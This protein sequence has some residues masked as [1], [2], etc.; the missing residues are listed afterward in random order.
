MYSTRQLILVL[1]SFLALSACDNS[2]DN[3]DQTLT[4]QIEEP[5]TPE[6]YYSQAPQKKVE[7][8]G[9]GIL[10]V[11]PSMVFP[12]IDI[13]SSI[14]ETTK[15]ISVLNG[16]ETEFAL[17]G[18]ETSGDDAFIIEQ[19]E[20]AA[21]I[22]PGDTCSI[23]VK[24][25]PPTVGEFKGALVFASEVGIK[26]TELT[27]MAFAPKAEDKPIAMPEPP[28]PDAYTIWRNKKIA[29]RA[30]ARP[31]FAERKTPP[32]APPVQQWVN[33]DKDY[34][35]QKTPTMVSTYPVDRTFKLTMERPINVISDH[36]VIS[37]LPGIAHF[38]VDEIVLGTDGKT[39]ILDKGDAFVTRFEPL[40]KL[41]DRRVN[42]CV[43]RIIRKKDGAAFYLGNEEGEKCFAHIV[44]AEGV[45]GLT[46]EVDNRNW[47]KYG[48]AFLTAT[49]S[50]AATYGSTQLSNAQ[51]INQAGTTLTDQLGE[52]TSQMIQQ[53]IDLAPIVTV[54]AGER[55]GVQLDTDLYLKR[56]EPIK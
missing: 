19:N 1:G 47:E 55:A 33:T 56:P 30:K 39:P 6:G 23:L 38:T 53:N 2:T 13:S 24:F 18:V 25:A 51:E 3:Q 37:E 48:S 31:V 28:K 45:T 9:P 41:G 8:K 22:Q 7:P 35:S 34:S 20:C 11:V 5:R 43:F 21:P 14:Y 40:T 12:K 10:S 27:G 32:P 52:I 36:K 29:A 44:D 46:G 16:G 4:R 54:G 17:A 26:K 42:Y 50:A 49:L 15:Q